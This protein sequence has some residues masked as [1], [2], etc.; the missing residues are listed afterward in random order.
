MKSYAKGLHDI[1]V[2]IYSGLVQLLAHTY[3]KGQKMSE[4]SLTPI[5]A[6][7]IL[8]ATPLTAQAGEAAAPQILEGVTRIAFYGDSLTDGSDYPS[9]VVNT[10]NR[11]YPGRNFQLINGAVCGHTADN[12]LQRLD[13][14]IL[15]QKPDLTVIL[16]GTNDGLQNLPLDQYATNMR[17]LIHRLQAN[18]SKV[19]LV[20]LTGSTN[21]ET[22]TKLRPFSEEIDRVAAELK[23]PVADAWTYFEKEQ[24]SGKEMYVTAGDVHHSKDGFLA[25]G[26]IVL[27]LLGVPPTTELV[28][29]TSPSAGT[30]TEWEES[31]GFDPKKNPAPTEVKEWKKYTPEEWIASR[32]WWY[33]P[34]VNRGAWLALQG[35]AKGQGAF[36]RAIYNA[37]ADGIYELQLGG[38]K[39]LQ[40]WVNG[41][42]VYDL[43]INN[44]FHPNAVRIPV[45]LHKGANEL[46]FFAVF[47]VYAGVEPL[48]K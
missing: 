9:Y 42:K 27:S 5:L 38:G 44:G 18:G 32:E 46:V 29:E 41:K 36:G 47:C 8:S 37:P 6:A 26:R 22:A 1:C 4:K 2:R 39:P 7:A 35:D 21:P 23:I 12:L 13:R 19:A 24:K 16:I 10:L 15:S 31:E 25:M 33:K 43:P 11:T 3:R 14:D 28:T 30:L 20:N 40:A 48:Q 17:Y 34:L 45:K